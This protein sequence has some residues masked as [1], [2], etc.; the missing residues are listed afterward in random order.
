MQNN[1]NKTLSCIFP[2]FGKASV[3]ARDIYFDLLVRILSP[4]FFEGFQ[5]VF[6]KA[7]EYEKK[8][9]EAAKKNREIENPGIDN[10]FRHFLL[11]FKKM[12]DMKIEE[13]TQRIR[14]HSQC[15]DFFDDL[16]KVVVKSHIVILTCSAKDSKLITEKFYETVNVNTFIHKCYIEISKIF[17]NNPKLFY[18]DELLTKYEIKNSTQIFKCDRETIFNNIRAGIKSALIQTLPMRQIIDEYLNTNISDVNEQYI[19]NVKQMI[20][21]DLDKDDKSNVNLLENSHNELKNDNEIKQN[22]EFDLD[23]KE[24][25]FGRKIVDTANENQN[26][27]TK[28]EFDKS[29]FD[30]KQN[31]HISPSKNEILSVSSN[32]K[33][34][35]ENVDVDVDALFNKSTMSK[36]K[37][38]ENDM[39][40]INAI[41]EKNI[42]NNEKQSE[43][44]K[45]SPKEQLKESPKEQLKESPKEQPKESP[46]EQPKESLKEQQNTNPY[47]INIDRSL[48]RN[49]DNHYSD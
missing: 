33:K 30:T 45:E 27:N 1:S 3:D 17:Y 32:T 14:A 37:K 49:N 20:A 28:S 12:S 18:T 42:E 21:H 10:L 41:K 36:S 47:E 35:K 46:K 44:P 40:F 7:V 2:C 4:L 19:T 13:E 9:D 5:S 48:K 39:F 26:I 6:T 22:D 43:Q 8:Y 24:F 23:L 15:A 11:T 29:I 16:I 31:Q 38:N 34:N 25:I